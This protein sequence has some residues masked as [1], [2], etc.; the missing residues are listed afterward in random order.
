MPLNS[1][2]QRASDNAI[3]AAAIGL[4]GIA[5]Y[6]ALGALIAYY[7]R[8]KKIALEEKS[9]KAGVFLA[10]VAAVLLL[11]RLTAPAPLPVAS[12]MGGHQDNPQHGGQIQGVG[13]NHLEAVVE[14]NGT[15]ALYVMG[16]METLPFPLAQSTLWGK[17]QSGTEDASVLLHATPL[18]GEPSGYSSVFTGEVPAK[19][20]GKPLHLTLSVPLSG[21]KRQVAFDVAPGKLPSAGA[22]SVMP[23][24]DLSA[25]R[26]VAAPVTPE[27]QSLFLTPGG[28]YTAAD[29]AANGGLTP[30]QKFQGL[31]ANHHLHPKKGTYTCPITKTQANSMFPWIV[32]GKTYLFCCPPCISEFVKQA[33]EHPGTLKPP[34]SY[35]QM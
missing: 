14:P 13:E 19:F 33:K 10:T 7:E 26:V 28:A 12:A 30:T 18:T 20:V 27:E 34:N 22:G 21:Q 9:V 4:I 25:T 32:G 23:S 35:L 11:W 2:S 16:I 1:A 24:H 31:M 17:V 8:R 3:T 5:V 15:V 6:F 29:I